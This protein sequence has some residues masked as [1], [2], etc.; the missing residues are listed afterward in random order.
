MRLATEPRAGN[1]TLTLEQAVSGWKVGD[2]LVMPDT[3]H[4][5]ESEVTGAGWINAQNQWEELT[6]QAI[7]ADGQTITLT[8]AAAVRSPGRARLEQRPGFP[9]ARRAT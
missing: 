1:T 9:A 7:S 8:S 2:R 5:K 3:R 6:I 4:I